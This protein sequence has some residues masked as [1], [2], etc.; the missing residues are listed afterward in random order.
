M[1]STTTTAT[2]SSAAEEK[3]IALKE[4]QKVGE[5]LT[6]LALRRLRHDYLT[7]AAIT[8]LLILS[9]LSASAPL[10]TSAMD[11]SYARTDPEN[12]YLPL[13]TEG[14]P[15]GTDHLGR[16]HLARLLYGGRVSLTVGLL[17]AIG[18]AIIG[19]SIGLVS[20]YYQGGRLGIIDDGIMWF[21]TT[22]TSIPTLLLL[23]LLSSV[24][25]PSMWTLIMVLTGISWSGTM[26]LVRGETLAQRSRDYV[27]SAQAV[28][29]PP[30][31]IMFT[32][33]L[34][35]V[36]SVLIV[37][38]ALGIGSLILVESAL[39]FIGV[40][41]REPMPSWGNMLTKAQ[42][43]FHPA[44]FLAVIPGGLITVTVL[45]LY[46]IGDGVRDAFDPQAKKNT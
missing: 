39:S 25:R 40:G 27:L 41:I 46:I 12:K 19:V 17:A 33:I 37:S 7:L 18:S 24:L 35:N 16:D 6:A 26:R 23:I 20:G 2:A 10:I 31:R 32:H 3:I 21:V 11:V 29:A 28:G 4:P 36:L 22:L 5:S 45:C 14:H 43:S 38:L 8:V 34:P 44:P 13:G 30:L 1:A 9:L 15:L 42:S